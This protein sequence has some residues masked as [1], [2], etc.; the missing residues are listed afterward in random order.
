VKLAEQTLG[1]PQVFLDIGS[2]LAEKG[3]EIAPLGSDPVRCQVTRNCQ[4]FSTLQPEGQ[5]PKASPSV[6]NQ[7]PHKSST[8]INQTVAAPWSNKM[9][10]L[11]KGS[12]TGIKKE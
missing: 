10:A 8:L 3:A 5:T 12:L 7:S 11:T 9:A 1:D 6:G 2:M 4:Y